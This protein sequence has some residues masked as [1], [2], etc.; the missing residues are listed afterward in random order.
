M[1]KPEAPT[2]MSPEQFMAGIS[3]YFDIE[4]SIDESECKIKFEN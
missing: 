2:E 3:P 1:M 4:R